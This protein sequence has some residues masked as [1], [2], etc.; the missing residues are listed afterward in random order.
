MKADSSQ[1]PTYDYSS[2]DIS[3]PTLL[4]S[5]L[6]SAHRIFLLHNGSSLAH[7]FSKLDRFKFVSLLDRF[8]TRFASHWEPTLHGTPATDFLGGMKLAAGGELGVGVGE[9][10]WG[11]GEREVLEDFARRTD[12]LVDLFVTRYGDVD[13]DSESAEKGSKIFSHKSDAPLE[14]WMGAG[15]EQQA[16]DGIV[17]SGIGAISQTCLRD[18]S[19]WSRWVYTYGEH[20]YGVKESPS[21]DKNRRRKKGQ[22]SKQNKTIA[23]QKSPETEQPSNL[24]PPIGIPRSIIAAADK[25][26]DKATAGVQNKTQSVPIRE[27]TAKEKLPNREPESWTRYLTLGYGTAWGPTDSESPTPQPESV[28]KS[29]IQNLIAQENNGHFL[30]GMRGDPEDESDE[31]EEDKES[32]DGWN[33]RL[34]LRTL[35]IELNSESAPSINTALF[36][37]EQDYLA[38]DPMPLFTR[39]ESSRSK[40]TNGLNTRQRLRVVIYAHRPFIYILLFDPSTAS[41]SIPPFYRHLHT[42]LSPLRSLLLRSTGAQTARQRMA[43]EPG[44]FP[45]QIAKQEGV[46]AAVHDHGSLSTW[47]WLPAIPRPFSSSDG[48]KTLEWTRQD[49]ISAHLAAVEILST[50]N[51]EER[52]RSVK[53]GRGWWVVWARQ[54]KESDGEMAQHEFSEGGPSK[55]EAL[56]PRGDREILIVRKTKEAGSGK[57]RVVSGWGFGESND[58]SKLE[59]SRMGIGFDP[60]AYMQGIVRLGR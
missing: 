45:A 10:E 59:S 30:I 33:R 53:T 11:S 27:K 52:E 36:A 47:S 14:P 37:S 4:V 16:A 57:S 56:R 29:R 3:P 26:L 19:Q 28:V 25:S 9:E 58:S 1:K 41:L 46:W 15:R 40:N 31:L 35:H 13:K 6:V 43:S 21:F 54:H 32:T 50:V 55:Q 5:Q 44:L 34:M 39:S 38:P 2:R 60:R 8:W 20:A 48:D 22:E 18:I 23:K 17:F 51:L 12:G 49:A 24:D 7:L 42:F